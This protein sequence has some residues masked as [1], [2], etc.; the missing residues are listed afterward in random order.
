[1]WQLSK[2]RQMQNSVVY[3]APSKMQE[4]K[5]NVKEEIYCCWYTASLFRNDDIKA[6][7]KRFSVA[8]IKKP[9]Q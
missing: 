1:M 5:P 2:F 7:H 8:V 6:T 3:N 9:S 4:I